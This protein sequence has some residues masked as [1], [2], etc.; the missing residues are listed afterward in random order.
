MVAQFDDT[1]SRGEK[2]LLPSSRILAVG[3]VSLGILT[4]QHSDEAIAA[5]W[6]Y[7]ALAGFVLVQV[8]WYEIV[9][10]FPINRKV[11]EMGKVFEG[12]K[13]SSL[14]DT[15]QKELIA[16]LEKWKRFHTVR[17]ILPLVG[18]CISLAAVL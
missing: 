13:K 5:M 7:Y 18:A 17:V 11:R 12:N 2:Y 9:F 15:Q 16:N 3:L 14:P 4:S 8:A 1:I 10:I 6:K